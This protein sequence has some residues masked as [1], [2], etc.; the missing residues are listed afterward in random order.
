VLSCV[1]SCVQRHRHDFCVGHCLL[2]GP[3][4]PTPPHPTPPHP[5]RP[6]PTPL[7]PLRPGRS[8][9]RR[10]ALPLIAPRKG[11]RA[12]PGEAHHAWRRRPHQRLRRHTGAQMHAH[13]R[14]PASRHA[15]SPASP[16]PDVR[17][18]APL[19]AVLRAMEAGMHAASAARGGWRLGQLRRLQKQLLSNRGGV[20][21][22][23]GTL[24]VCRL[25]VA[26]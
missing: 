3:S 10:R 7:A 11:S 23:P 4:R 9:R 1:L 12:V 15:S 20:E 16:L 26:P 19:F 14:A 5:T 21:Q 18:G 6:H 2:S 25:V 24:E 17:R 8:W 22:G 13:T